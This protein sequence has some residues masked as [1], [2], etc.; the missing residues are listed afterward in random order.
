MSFIILFER[1]CD[2][3]IIIL[4]VFV[5]LWITCSC[6]MNWESNRLCVDWVVRAYHLLPCYAGHTERCLERSNAF[7][8]SV[9]PPLRMH[10]Y[11]W[12]FIGYTCWW[13][14][15]DPL[16][17]ICRRYALSRFFYLIL[18]ANQRFGLRLLAC[19]FP[20]L[21]NVDSEQKPATP[22]TA[23]TFLESIKINKH[24]GLWSC[25]EHK[26]E[27]LITVQKLLRPTR[28]CMLL[29]FRRSLRL[30]TLC[31]FLCKCCS[32]QVGKYL[33]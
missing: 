15:A 32:K 1:V 22:T 13:A 10:W 23:K 20:S 17:S 8:M 11:F 4:C 30:P 2:Q 29:F 27:S 28:G 19:I 26:S 18:P 6:D 24:V 9:R 7:L 16:A 31:C 21:L 33:D 3:C 12:I 5:F 25:E 14:S